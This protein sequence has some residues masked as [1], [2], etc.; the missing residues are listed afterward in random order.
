MAVCIAIRQR[1]LIAAVI[2][3]CFH[4][5]RFGAAPGLRPSSAACI[6][7]AGSV[8]AIG[9]RRC[10]EETEQRAFRRHKERFVA[11]GLSKA[12]NPKRFQI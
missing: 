8:R 3:T 5:L 10:I 1:P 11:E 6:R 2:E 12:R 9:A 4:A 7:S